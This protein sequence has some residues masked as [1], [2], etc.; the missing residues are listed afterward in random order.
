MKR[1]RFDLEKLLELR[2]YREKEAE[3][4]LARA[5]G[6][7]A[8]IEAKLRA[9]AEERVAVA[10]GRFAPGRTAADMR[11]AELYLLRL[12]KTKE[13]LLEEAA[14]AEL[15]VA[16]AREAFME[17]SRDRKI[18]DK[19]KDKRKAEYRKTAADEEVKAID[20]ISG[21]SS[22]RTALSGDTAFPNT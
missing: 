7:L 22:A 3:Q 18:L 21:G 6:E 10:R 15:A 20:D 9:L 13:K 4:A 2:V 19:L 16:A 12:E 8:A 14:K 17:A 11:S 5:M 1:F